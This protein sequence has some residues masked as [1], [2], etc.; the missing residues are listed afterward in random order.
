MQRRSELHSAI[1]LRL[2]PIGIQTITIN[3]DKHSSLWQYVHE[4]DNFTTSIGI[5]KLNINGSKWNRKSLANKM[6]G[7]ASACTV[8][9]RLR[10]KT[11]VVS[12][13]KH[14]Y[15]R[16]DAHYRY[17][18]VQCCLISELLLV[19]FGS[20]CV[21]HPSLR[22]NASTRPQSA[23]WMSDALLLTKMESI[24]F[25]QTLIWW[26]FFTRCPAVRTYRLF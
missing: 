15:S 18:H 26:T 5:N 17:Y 22:R 3:T 12:R 8:H 9:E 13:Y 11:L 20:K 16:F 2:P 1:I 25:L 14:R 10:S 24:F 23:C 19:F 7:S 21:Y 4:H 6:P